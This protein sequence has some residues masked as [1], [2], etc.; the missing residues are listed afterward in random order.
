MILYILGI[1]QSE[2]ERG[3]CI[4]S[5]NLSA[6]EEI[7]VGLNLLHETRIYLEKFDKDSHLLNI[8]KLL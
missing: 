5:L 1:F 2:R 6:S 4:N 8:F 7:G 3:G